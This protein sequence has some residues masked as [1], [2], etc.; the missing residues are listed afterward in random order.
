LIEKLHKERPNLPKVNIPVSPKKGLKGN[1]GVIKV[2]EY[3][4]LNDIFLLKS[5]Q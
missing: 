2:T 3:L 4:T 1:F 5:N